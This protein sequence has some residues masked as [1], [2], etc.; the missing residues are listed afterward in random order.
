MITT[1]SLIRLKEFYADKTVLVT[2]HMGF[3]G[4]RLHEMLGKLGCQ[5]LYGMDR[6]AGHNGLSTWCYTNGVI[7]VADEESIETFFSPKTDVVFHL[8]A[9]TEVR[10]S[11]VRPHTTLSNNLNSTLNILEKCRTS[12]K[13]PSV[14]IASSDKAYGRLSQWVKEYKEGDE[15]HADA[16]PYSMSKTLCDVMATR[17]ARLY[18]DAMNVKI[19]RACNVYGPGQRNRTTLITNTI[20]RLLDDKPP[21]L[22]AKSNSEKREWMFVDDVVEAYLLLGAHQSLPFQE[23]FNVGTGHRM[24]P[25]QVV[26]D[27]VQRM[28][29]VSGGVVVKTD[30]VEQIGDQALNC[31]RFNNTFP[32]WAPLP[33]STGIQATIGWYE[34]MRSKEKK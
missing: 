5:A 22:H 23:A 27:L 9:D 21:E 18:P 32:E 15:L 6:K 12:T 10:A 29:G 30:P 16:D 2:G 17:Y 7:D 1:Q 26:G 28:N 3:I 8:A 13:K 20:T 24:T 25:S 11:L 14:V 31:D 33:W 4:G 19:L 34:M